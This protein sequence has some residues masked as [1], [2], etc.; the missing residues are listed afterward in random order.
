VAVAV[1]RDGLRPALPEAQEQC[2]V[3]FEELITACWH[4]DPTIRPTFL[5]IMTRLSTLN[6]DSS[7]GGLSMTSRTSTSSSGHTEDDLFGPKHQQ[8]SSQ[9]QSSS[10]GGSSSDG[11]QSGERAGAVVGAAGLRAPEGEVTIVFSDITRAASLWEFDP[12][13]MRDATLLHNDVLR[14][15]LRRHRGYEV[16]FLRDRNS[17]EGSFCMA[18]QHPSDALAWCDDVQRALLAADWPE[19]LL[20]HPG[21]AEE[22]GDTDDRYS[23]S[24]SLA[25]VMLFSSLAHLRVSCCVL[26]VAFHK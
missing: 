11:R 22:W 17:G 16:A 5:E 7:A 10:D 23:P 9:G 24:E 18:F 4:Q 1:I 19:A 12:A 8:T 25:R 21:A 26:R 2:P 3:E 20:E 14:S 6:G 13:A 15:A